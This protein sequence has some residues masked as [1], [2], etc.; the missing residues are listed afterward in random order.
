MHVILS[1]AKNLSSIPPRG[2]NKE[3]FFAALR[4]TCELTS[5]AMYSFAPPAVKAGKMITR[6]AKEYQRLLDANL[7]HV[8][9]TEEEN[10][11]YRKVLEGLAAR[12][13]TLTP[14]EERLA[15]LLTLLIEDFEERHYALR[16]ASPVEA[17]LELMRANNL[18]QKDL[19][20]VFRTPSIASE[21]IK[22]KR[23]LT[24]EHIRRLSERFHVS[25]ELF[26]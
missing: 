23:H 4:M 1:A 21:V 10:E 16:R 2:K 18:K 15:D 12:S 13:S 24:L 14:A 25:P 3:R 19:V 8:I 20:D 17:L 26:L 5:D 22:G 6:H 11:Y 7:P 9:E